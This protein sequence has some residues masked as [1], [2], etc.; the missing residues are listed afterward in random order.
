[1]LFTSVFVLAVGYEQDDATSDEDQWPE[2]RHI[3]PQDNG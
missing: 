1:M 3:N 2:F